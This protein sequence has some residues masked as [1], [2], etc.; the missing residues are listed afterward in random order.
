[1]YQLYIYDLEKC[2]QGEMRYSER[3]LRYGKIILQKNEKR[4][5]IKSQNCY[6]IGAIRK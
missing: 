3:N 2:M 6:K 5:L 4:N 1:V